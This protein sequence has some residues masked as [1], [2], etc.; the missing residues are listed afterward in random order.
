LLLLTAFYLASFQLIGKKV[1]ISGLVTRKGNQV[2]FLGTDGRRVEANV[3][4]AQIAAAGIFLRFPNWMDIIGL[5][6]YHRLI[7]FRGMQE[8]EFHYGKKPDA[9]WLRS[10][11]NDPILLFLYKYQNGFRPLIDTFYTESVYFKGNRER[12]IV[13]PQGY[14]IQ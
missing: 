1:G 10:Y 8:N 7:T 9:N 5:H 11:V 6:T 13:T 14:I 12:L 2:A 3:Q 4:G